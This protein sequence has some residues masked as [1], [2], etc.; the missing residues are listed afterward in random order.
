MQFTKKPTPRLAS[1]PRFSVAKPFTSYVAHQ[2]TPTSP[3]RLSR[4]PDFVS[5]VLFE[6]DPHSVRHNFVAFVAFQVE[7]Q[8]FA[9]DGPRP[10]IHAAAVGQ[11]K[12]AKA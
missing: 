5:F 3:R 4:T 1:M 8:G 11:C 12:T 10:F 6:I 2:T 9:V 7:L